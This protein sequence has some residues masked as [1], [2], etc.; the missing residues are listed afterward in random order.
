RQA[1]NGRIGLRFT[2]GGFGTPFFAHAGESVQLRVEG[3]ELLI[4]RAGTRETLA[5]ATLLDAARVRQELD[6]ALPAAE[7]R[8]DLGYHTTTS[9]TTEVLEGADDTSGALLGDWYG[10][11]C[12]VLEELRAGA[13]DADATRCQI[14]PEHFDL[15]I[16]LGDADAE[17]RAAFGASPGDAAHPDPYLYVSPWAEPPADPH[18]NDTAFRGASLPY[19]ALTG[20]PVT[21]RARALEFFGT[22]REILAPR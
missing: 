7:T 10:F 19:A 17:G 14:W 6:P 4:A 12:S 16:E 1:A 2:S 3:T 20:D 8:V 18:W 5:R 9:L 21:A 15:A 11:G 22:A 13:P